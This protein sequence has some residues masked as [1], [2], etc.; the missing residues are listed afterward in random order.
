MT[1][2]L[3]M[4]W[5]SEE[6]GADIRLKDE[7]LNPTGTF[8]ARGA[9]VG[10]SRAKQLGATTI[11]LPTAGNAGAAWAAYGARAGLH[12]VVAMPNDA[13]MLT[14]HEV[15]RYGAQL[16]LVEGTIATSL[17]V[18]DRLFGVRVR[19]PDRY[20]RSLDLLGQTLIDSPNGGRIPLA[21]VGTLRWMGERT[22]LARER[23][24]PVV[25]VTA[26]LEGGDLG[27]AMAR[28]K[29]RLQGLELPPGVTLEFGGLYA[30]QQKA[31]TQ[32]WADVAAL[33]K[34]AEEKPKSN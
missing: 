16:H 10:I 6:L 23:L 7:G 33:L 12:V 29:E 34:K 9:A 24:R 28:V 30:E 20:H 22:E 4:P 21:A 19:Y 14:Q 13:P 17:R 31:F 32:L 11:A 26:R 2:L 3:A 25:H 18:G 8:K 27:T 15:R 5:L 1:P